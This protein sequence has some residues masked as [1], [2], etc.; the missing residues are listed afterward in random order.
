[1][2]FMNL[3]NCEEIDQN[4]SYDLTF[5]IFPFSA[6]YEASREPYEDEKQ[7]CSTLI[8]YLQRHLAAV[9]PA[10]TGGDTP[11]DGHSPRASGDIDKTGP[12]GKGVQ[13][14]FNSDFKRVSNVISYSQCQVKK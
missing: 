9:D 2:V 6:E 10:P 3:N 13:G 12:Q 4:D 8:T 1:M 14:N 11:P 7:L 5:I